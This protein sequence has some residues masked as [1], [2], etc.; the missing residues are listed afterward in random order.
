M[1]KQGLSTNKKNK[2][3][4]TNKKRTRN[5]FLNET[6]KQEDEY[7]ESNDDDDFEYDCQKSE[8]SI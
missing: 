2:D 7:E 3:Q 4:S 8:K 5:Q 6:F 1:I